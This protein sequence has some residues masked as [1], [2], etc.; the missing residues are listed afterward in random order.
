M[1][2]SRA[3][4]TRFGYSDVRRSYGMIGVFLDLEGKDFYGTSRGGNDSLWTGSFYGVGLNGELRPADAP[5]VAVPGPKAKTQE[6]IEQDLA[7]DIPTLFI[8]ASAAPQ[9][10]QYLVDPAMNRLAS[11][12]D[13][14]IPYLMEQLNSES[15]RERLA[16]GI[17]PRIGKRVVQALIDTVLYGDTSRVSQ[18]IY[19]LGEIKDPMAS[20]ALGK[21]LVDTTIS[22]R[23]RGGA[24]EALLKM[25]AMP[26]KPYLIR[27]L[28]DTVELVRGR[29]LERSRI[30]TTEELR[31]YIL[32]LLDDRSQIVRY[33]IQFGLRDRGVDSLSVA[34]FIAASLVTPAAIDGANPDPPATMPAPS[35]PPSPLK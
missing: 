27:A 7:K 31:Q 21:K 1:A 11:M 34:Q 25:D 30:A 23:L 2:T 5:V 15:P 9:K 32:P 16:L 26:A 29:A 35:F 22:W 19:T 14:S 24:G 10:Y 4:Q 17:M 8:Q 20:E 12:A 3:G 33:Q 18:A 28:A 6:E 13:S